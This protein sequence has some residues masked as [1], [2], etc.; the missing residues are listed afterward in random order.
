MSYYVEHPAVTLRRNVVKLMDEYKRQTG[1]GTRR[2][3]ERAGLTRT[4]LLDFKT[5][6]RTPNY[7][8]VWKLATAM[9]IPVEW[10][11]R[12]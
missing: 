5:G 9:E 2:L 11:F 4:A 10:F 3:A 6:R 12:R 8:S 1:Y 7:D